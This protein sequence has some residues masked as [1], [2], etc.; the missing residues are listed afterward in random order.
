MTFLIA[1]LLALH[2][3]FRALYFF[4]IGGTLRREGRRMIKSANYRGRWLRFK[5]R[6]A[7]IL[8][9]DAVTFMLLCLLTT[10][11]WAREWSVPVSLVV[12]AILIVIGM[13]AKISAEHAI[14]LRGYY[15]YDF[16]SPRSDQ[17]WVRTGIY[18]F[19]S[20]PMYGLGYLHAFGLAILLRSELGFALALFDW[21]AVWTFFWTYERPH[22]EKL[23]I[24]NDLSDA[25]IARRA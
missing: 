5:Q 22:V 19:F 13:A 18:R 4:Y 7:F 8:R 6:A 11:S 15:W 25:G 17:T 21:G 1:V 20:N 12:G 10:G 9:G 3:G 2:L 14:G 24:N 16:F 23:L